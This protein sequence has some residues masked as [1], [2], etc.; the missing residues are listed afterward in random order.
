MVNFSSLSDYELVAL[1]QAGDSGAYKEIYERYARVLL[2]HAYN[3]TRN[4]VEAQD[5]VQEVFA[6]L[7]A[8]YDQVDPENNLVGY[9][10]IALRNAFYNQVAK[11]NVRKKYLA[12][13]NQFSIDNQTIADYRVRERMLTEL[14][15]KEIKKLPTK[16]RE[17][18]LL[19]RTQHLTHKQIAEKLA[20]SEQTVS[21]Q[22]TK[23]IKILRVRL[24]V[25]GFLIGLLLK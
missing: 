8:H 24:G 2:N 18:F 5:L 21:K 16:M 4:R 12:S 25:L 23:A 7:W 3:K 1:L 6:N 10:Y 15:E 11:D 22:I 20:I 13:I 19:S 14:I 17:V 9:L